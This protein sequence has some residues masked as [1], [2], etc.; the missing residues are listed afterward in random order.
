MLADGLEREDNRRDI[1]VLHL[2]EQLVLGEVNQR[3]PLLVALRQG[4][5]DST[6]ERQT[7]NILRSQQSGFPAPTLR[8]MRNLRPT[9]HGKL[10]HGAE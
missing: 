2:L 10:V 8:A 7:D 6:R 5:S 4:P 9:T 3:F 1:A